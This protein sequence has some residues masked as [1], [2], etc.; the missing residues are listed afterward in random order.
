M[1]TKQVTNKPTF[2]DE[3]GFIVVANIALLTR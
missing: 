1:F 3:G 2:V